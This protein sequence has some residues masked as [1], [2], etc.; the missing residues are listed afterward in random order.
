[1]ALPFL[2]AP[3]DVRS[4][5]NPPFLMHAG[6]LYNPFREESLLHSKAETSKTWF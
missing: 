1:M 4:G 5:E 3:K 6:S 2:S